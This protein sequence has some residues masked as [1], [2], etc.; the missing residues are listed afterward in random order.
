MKVI[1][2]FKIQGEFQMKRFEKVS[3]DEM[4]IKLEPVGTFYKNIPNKTCIHCG[5]EFKEQHES[6]AVECQRC[7]NVDYQN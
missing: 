7:I 3:V 5:E 4:K 1:N 2:L 6:Y